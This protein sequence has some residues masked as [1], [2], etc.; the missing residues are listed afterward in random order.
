VRGMPDQQQRDSLHRRIADVLRELRSR[1]Q[2]PGMT[3]FVEGPARRAWRSVTLELDVLEVKCLSECIE[4][5]FRLE[6]LARAHQSAIDWR[7]KL[8]LAV[9]DAKG[10]P[11]ALLKVLRDFQLTSDRPSQ[12]SSKHAWLWSVYV[13]LLTVDGPVY[14]RPWSEVLAA[15]KNPLDDQ[16]GRPMISYKLKEGPARTEPFGEGTGLYDVVPG[17]EGRIIH[18]PV[19]VSRAVDI[20]Q[21]HTG[22]KTRAAMIKALE[23]AA[24]FIDK[25]RNELARHGA[26]EE[27]L[28]QMFGP[29]DV[30]V[31]DTWPRESKPED[32]K[33]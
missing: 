9:N 15:A 16:Q 31:P 28:T 7:G 11:S 1:P 2:P 8:Q 5:S 24:D 14:L 22:K 12:A 18:A 4:D 19:D 30:R 25:A 32:S 27:Q 20:L 29:R 17:G 13:E 26:D 10:N 3:G 33:P 6:E 23:R 21:E